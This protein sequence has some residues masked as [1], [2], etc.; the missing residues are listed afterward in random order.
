MLQGTV[1]M[2][3]PKPTDGAKA[4]I[5]DRKRRAEELAREMKALAKHKRRIQARQR[6]DRD[7]P[8]EAATGDRADVLVDDVRAPLPDDMRAPI[9]N[10][11]EKMQALRAEA[12]SLPSFSETDIDPG[13]LA[14]RRAEQRAEM[15]RAAAVRGDNWTEELVEARIEEAFRTLAR[16]SGGRT[17]PREFGN[18]MPTPIRAYS[19]MV[20]QAGNKSLRRSLERLARREG[21]PT[22]EEVRRMEDALMWA[23]RYLRGEHPD[24]AMFANLGGMWKA[25]EANISK[26][27]RE[28]GIHRQVFYRDRKTAIRMILEGLKQD[29]K[30]PT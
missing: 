27:C 5:A 24:L 12:N 6:D 8:I 9:G 1:I 28:L 18:A 23:T 16:S 19:D 7:W 25:W 10:V 14:R 30:I 4:V 3:G 21:P 22:G 15:R 17:G 13:I 2:E 20:N 29:G 26:R 11:D